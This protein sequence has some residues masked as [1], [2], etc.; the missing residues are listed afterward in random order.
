M[1]NVDS[2]KED[3]EVPTKV[4]I[5]E[6]A[7]VKASY[8]VYG[9]L[10]T[11]PVVSAAAFISLFTPDDENPS[12]SQ[13]WMHV[14]VP[15]VILFIVQLFSL[16]SLSNAFGMD[17]IQERNECVSLK[18]SMKTTLSNLA[19]VS[20]LLLGTVLGMLQ[21]RSGDTLEAKWYGLILVM[22]VCFNLIAVIE[23]V[24]G[25]LYIDPLSE[26]AAT[27]FVYENLIYFGEPITM[28]IAGFLNFALATLLFVFDNY[29]N[30]AGILASCLFW[31][32]A[33]RL[34]V[35]Y[36]TLSSWSNPFVT[37]AE[38]EDRRVIFQAIMGAYTGA[39]GQSTNVQVVPS[40]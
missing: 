19:L 15:F 5:G 33:M 4:T 13:V 11:A 25:T 12:E 16:S 38:R 39:S 22:S 37:A 27:Q 36:Q 1:A 35:T 2:L 20:A 23:A 24:L 31:F 8:W 21:S 7:K 32:V 34:A 6:Q 3:P 17:I 29:G 26:I 18:T 30:E 10:F 28:T 9:G 40:T 14:G